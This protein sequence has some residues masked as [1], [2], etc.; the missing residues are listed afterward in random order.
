VTTSNVILVVI[1]ASL[2]S[3]CSVMAGGFSHW[4]ASLLAVIVLIPLKLLN[5]RKKWFAFPMEFILVACVT[6]IVMNLVHLYLTPL[7][8]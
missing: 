2:L 1:L 6:M 5:D 3:G 8:F 4:P 7:P